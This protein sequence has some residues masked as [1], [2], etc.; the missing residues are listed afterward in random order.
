MFEIDILVQDLKIIFNFKKLYKAIIDA[1]TE[2]IKTNLYAS[3]FQIKNSKC[4]RENKRNKK[5]EIIFP[6]KA[7][8][9]VMLA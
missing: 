8:K 1:I 7:A 4:I 6:P 2:T 3:K 5:P 9:F